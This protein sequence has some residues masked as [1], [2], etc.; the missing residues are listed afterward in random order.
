LGKR[1]QT[2]MPNIKKEYVVL[3]GKNQLEYLQLFL[4]SWLRG[5][6][7]IVIVPEIFLLMIN[8]LKRLPF[9]R[10][11]IKKSVS[12]HQAF[13]SE[14]KGLWYEVNKE[15]IDLTLEFYNKMIGGDN[16]LIRCY[17][18][19][20]N[21]CKFEA[22]LKKEISSSIF[23]L[24]EK[25]HLIRVSD[26]LIEKHIL[27][28]KSPIN[29]YVINYIER[30]YKIKHNIRWMAPIWG[31]PFLCMYYVWLFSEIIKR[32]IF[33]NKHKKSYKLSKE[34][35]WGFCRRT[36]RDDIVID[37]QRFKQKD[38][39][40]LKFQ[41]NDLHRIEAFEE[42][43]KRGFDT[44]SVPRLKI[45]I[46]KNIFNI[47]FLYFLLPLKSYFQ[48]FLNRQSYFFYYIILFHKRCFPIE[49]L[50]NLY[51][52]KCYI[53]TKD[54]GDIEDTIILNKYRTKSVIFH[55][56]DLTCYNAYHQAFVA[57]NVYFVWGDIHHDFNS[58]HFLVDRKINIGCIYKKAYRNALKNKSNIVRGIQGFRIERKV[59]TF[60]D[61]SFTNSSEYSEAFFLDYLQLI[62][63]F[64]K[65]KRNVNVLLKPKSSES[66]E[67]KLSG[68]NV[69]TYKKIWEELIKH[70][71][72]IFL[73]PLQH[74]IE[75]TIAISDICVSMAMNSSSTI[76]LICG[77]DGLY[78]DNTGNTCHPFAKKYKDIIVFEEE[79]LLLQQICNILDGRFSCKDFVT[80]K[81]IRK[82]DA[83][84]DDKALE[85]LK[86][87]LYRLTLP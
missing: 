37:N 2:V 62:K 15:T 61:T 71:N 29:N 58:S 41:N 18:E 63:S 5:L 84:S 67:K 31:F 7:I 55:W 25:L 38:I 70:D 34:A 19:M 43:K 42:A 79:N 54:W 64:C 56:S 76:A 30:K 3:S 68:E 48:L 32:G 39:L 51:N 85:R 72:F 14:H 23:I 73:N 74:G 60:C 20:F 1:I 45:N 13:L 10:R 9:I 26:V 53:S 50:M 21:T 6:K 12:E 28:T 59:V 16:K 80:E 11:Y 52:I 47:L 82:Y 40:I 77:K 44:I 33:F 27:I 65:K 35:T 87:D 36:I 66:Y 75:Q 49:I 86:E 22:Y 78:F 83:F 57:H 81:E 24:L 4:F 46:N 8:T 17:N 69:D